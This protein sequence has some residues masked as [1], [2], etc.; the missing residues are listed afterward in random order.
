MPDGHFVQL[1][2]LL[3][4]EASPFLSPGCQLLVV[5]PTPGAGSVRC[6]SASFHKSLWFSYLT[7]EVSPED[8]VFPKSQE[9]KKLL[10]FKNE[11]IY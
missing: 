8:A 2:Q 1:Q 4:I 11:S 6:G 10:Q 9:A 7:V 5:P 3:K